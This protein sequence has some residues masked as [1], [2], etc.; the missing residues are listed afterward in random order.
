MW[1]WPA[2]ATAAEVR[3]D[4]ACYRDRAPVSVTATGFTPGAVFA[5]ILDG[6]RVGGGLVEQAGAV[7]A[8]FP[9]PPLSGRQDTH[10]I[11]ILDAAGRADAAVFHVSRPG[12][13]LSPAPRDPLTAR[14]RFHVYAMGRG[15]RVTLRW[16][17][18][19]GRVA[20]TSSLGRAVG[21]C[22]RV[23]SPRRRLFP[24]RPAPGVWR[25]RFSS[26]RAATNLRVRVFPRS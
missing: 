16:I 14:V 11:G 2:V 22:G 26:R 24:F 4:A 8:T 18:P 1:V 19:S 10:A 3:V 20:L 6:V 9:A 25:L 17:S 21:P 7:Q 15:E 12:A 13:R 5:A 23:V